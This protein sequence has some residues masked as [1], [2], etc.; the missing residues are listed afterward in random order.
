MTRRR[1]S[2]LLRQ[3]RRVKEV[4]QVLHLSHTN[5][6]YVGITQQILANLH[7]SFSKMRRKRCFLAAFG[8][9]TT[10]SCE[11]SQTWPQEPQDEFDSHMSCKLSLLNC[12][13]IPSLLPQASLRRSL[14][15]PPK[16]FWA[17]TTASPRASPALLFSLR[18]LFR[19]LTLCYCLQLR[20]SV[21]S[22]PQLIKQGIF[23]LE[24]PSPLDD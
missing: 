21:L 3:L 7:S 17:S 1:T 4:H 10:M 22:I 24:S 16:P 9:S 8:C 6:N 11:T 23:V 2:S 20:H 14:E 19:L 5:C 15:I 18:S 13:T 12:K